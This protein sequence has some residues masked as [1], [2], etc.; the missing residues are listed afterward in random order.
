MF[1]KGECV[2]DGGA[3]CIHECHQGVK[4]GVGAQENEDVINSVSKSRLSGGK[5]GL[6]C[7]LLFP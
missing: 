2:F 5:L 4:L 7:V 3:D 6:W 1:G